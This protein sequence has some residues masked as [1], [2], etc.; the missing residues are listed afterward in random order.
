MEQF[1]QLWKEFRTLT[2][3]DTTIAED[4]RQTIREAANSPDEFFVRSLTDPK[5]QR[6]LATK[7]YE[8]ETLF[9]RFKDWIK[10]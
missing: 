8:G 9:D 6:Y 10:W 4:L 2:V 5:L 7:E 1:H 3:T